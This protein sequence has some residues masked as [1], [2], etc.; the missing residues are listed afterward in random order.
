M[1]MSDANDK[2]W[3]AMHDRA[4]K[5]WQSLTKSGDR[6]HPDRPREPAT[7]REPLK[8]FSKSEK[9]SGEEY[10]SSRSLSEIVNESLT[11]AGVDPERLPTEVREALER[12]SVHA[13]RDSCDDAP[14]VQ[15]DWEVISP[16]PK[17]AEQRAVYLTEMVAYEK[18][19]E[20]YAA[21]VEAWVAE[22]NRFHAYIEDEKDLRE[23]ERL[24]KKFG[25][26]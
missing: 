13:T 10:I 2:V 19:C 25:K 24:Q 14:Y 22:R 15:V 8:T 16:N 18:A 17:Y 12:T 3:R 6:Y 5:A 9:L 7:P 23:W 21:R 20:E 1:I 26:R 4:E 11:R